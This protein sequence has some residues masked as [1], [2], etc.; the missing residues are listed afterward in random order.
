M[1]MRCC[2]LFDAMY[3]SPLSLFMGEQVWDVVIINVS[4]VVDANG[5]V[6]IDVS[7]VAKSATLTVW[8]ELPSLL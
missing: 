8:V 2:P 6:G 7:K 1:P 4:R 3:V 5:V